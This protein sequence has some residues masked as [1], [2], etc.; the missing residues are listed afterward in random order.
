MSSNNNDSYDNEAN[1][2]AAQSSVADEVPLMHSSMNPPP[3]G[4]NPFMTLEPLKKSFAS[5][6]VVAVL[7]AHW[8][9]VRGPSLTMILKEEAC[10]LEEDE[11][12]FVGRF[13]L[14]SAV[15]QGEVSGIT[16]TSLPQLNVGVT[17]VLFQAPL[18]GKPDTNVQYCMNLVVPEHKTDRFVYLSSSVNDRLQWI[19]NRLLALLSSDITREDFCSAFMKPLSLFIAHLDV[20]VSSTIPPDMHINATILNDG[21]IDKDFLAAV[22][23]THLTYHQRTVI[24]SRRPLMANLW[25]RALCLQSS[26]DV[27]QLSRLLPETESA[28]ASIRFTPELF[29]QGVLST[30]PI[31]DSDVQLS[32]NPC[33]LIDVD[34][35]QIMVCKPF[36]SYFRMREHNKKNAI[37]APQSDLFH[38]LPSFK[39]AVCVKSMVSILLQIHSSLRAGFAM[40][41]RRWYFRKAAA[42][43]HYVQ[44]HITAN[45]L[46]HDDVG[47]AQNSIIHGDMSTSQNGS[48]SVRSVP[49]GVEA[50]E[51]LKRNRMYLSSE[52]TKFMKNLLELPTDEDVL[53]VL[54]AAELLRPGT[55]SKVCGDPIHVKDIAMIVRSQIGI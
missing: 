2:P 19:L 27:W 50:Q 41:W 25:L 33:C 30:V 18:L 21:T 51:E 37:T 23:S 54:S 3:M 1:Q 13:A 46:N 32:R 11:I 8:D 17:A 31:P 7:L 53:L 40:E 10:A 34:A 55:Y 20:W 16:Y 44:R 47:T 36:N 4:L 29:L 9:P 26:P 24:R 6:T 15:P 14:L 39:A 43:V 38:A 22:I 12:E 5:S 45:Y 28:A 35:Q 49:S 48:F 52:K 42:M